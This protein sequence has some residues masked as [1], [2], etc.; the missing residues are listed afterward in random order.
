MALALLLQTSGADALV[1]V[2]G[3]VA[4]ALV[5]GPGMDWPNVSYFSAQGMAKELYLPWNPEYNLW[6]SFCFS[7]AAVP[8]LTT[9]AS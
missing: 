4:L 1:E 6:Y 7:A 2:E 3:L 9:A 8:L 5:S